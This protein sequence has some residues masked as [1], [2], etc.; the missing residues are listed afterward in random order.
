MPT[1][2][3]NLLSSGRVTGN[4]HFFKVRLNHVPTFGPTMV[5]AEGQKILNF[6]HP[7]THKM[8]LLRVKIRR[9]GEM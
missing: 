5:G 9:L 6:Q 2:R 1:D 3:P 4:K 8:A 7:E